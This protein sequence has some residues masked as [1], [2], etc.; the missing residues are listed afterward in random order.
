MTTTT[1]KRVTVIT[2]YLHYDGSSLLLYRFLRWAASTHPEYGFDIL[3]RHDGEV[4][5]KLEQLSNVEEVIHLAPRKRRLIHRIES[6]LHRRKLVRLLITPHALYCNTLPALKWLEDFIGN[7]TGLPLPKT[8]I[9]V[10]ELGYWVQRS[11]INRES[12]QG[13]NSTI[14]AD[15]SLTGRNL[16]LT[17][18]ISDYMVIDEY[19][20]VKEVL[21]WKGQDLIRKEYGI[22]PSRPIVGMAGTI[23]WR[24]GPDLFLMIAKQLAD[25]MEYPPLFVWVG[26]FNDEL[27]EYQ[28]RCDIKQLGLESTVLFLGPKEN[29]YPYYDSMDLFLLSSREEPFGAVCLEA[30]A[31]EIPSICYRGCAGAESFISRGCGVVVERSDPNAMAEAIKELLDNHD[32]R[33]TLGRRAREECE[34]QYS[35]EKLL[36]QLLEAILNRDV[37]ASAPDAIQAP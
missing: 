16:E 13:L 14:I 10:R 18:G 9:H 19:C 30:G 27:F 32:R 4:R 12:F 22:S 3:Y 34:K 17:L 24:K 20:D 25:T 5:K 31:L 11:G 26:R 37:P 15:S 35:L 33:K 29:P 21:K 6:P 7:N 1:P 2:P 36:P 8:T 23:E 28:M